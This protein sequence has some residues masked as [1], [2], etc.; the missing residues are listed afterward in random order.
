MTIPIQYLGTVNMYQTFISFLFC[1]KYQ[2]LKGLIFML[3]SLF[4]VCNKLLKLPRTE[5]SVILHLLG[6]VC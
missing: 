1:S 3:F 2:L 6:E 4:F 5:K